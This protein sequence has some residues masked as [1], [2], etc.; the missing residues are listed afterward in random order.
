MGG[1]NPAA[2]IPQTS[3]DVSMEQIVAWNPDVIFI[4][5]YAGYTA[6]SI[7]GNPQWRSVTAVKQ[8]KVYKAPLWSTWSPRV[9]PIVLWMAMKTYPES[10]SDVDAESD[11]R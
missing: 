11:V 1:M 10:F 7:L 4:W 8:G 3:L 2:T 9:A 6:E 5:G